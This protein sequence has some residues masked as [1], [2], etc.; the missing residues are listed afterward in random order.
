MPPVGDFDLLPLPDSSCGDRGYPF[1]RYVTGSPTQAEEDV[2]EETLQLLAGLDQVDLNRVVIAGDYV[3]FDERARHALK[4]LRAKVISAFSAHGRRPTNVLVWGAPGSGKSFL[5]QEVARSLGDSARL[6]EANLAQV[7]E[8]GLRDR[9]NEAQSG[10]TDTICFIDELDAHP[11]Q[12]WPYELLLP[13]LEPAGTPVHRTVFIL[14]G[15]AGVDLKEFKDVVRSRPKGPDLLSRIPRGNEYTVPP[16]R[17]GDRI[18]VVTTQIR[19]AAAAEGRPVR[20]FEKFALFYV[21]STPELQTARQLRALA[22]ESARRIPPGDDRFRY[23]HLFAAGD[24]ENKRFWNQHEDARRRLADGFLPVLPPTVVQARAPARTAPPTP[25]PPRLGPANPR[26]RIAILPFLNISSNPADTYFSDG[27]T[28]ELI[29]TVSRIGELRVIARTSVTRFR[30]GSK[31]AAEAAR[32]LQVGTLLEGSVRRAGDDLRVTAQLI[33]VANEEPIW[34]MTFDRRLENVFAIQEELAQRIAHSLSA[35]LLAGER[36]TIGRIPT[37]SVEAYDLY[38]QGRQRFFAVTRDGYQSAIQLFERALSI[39]PAFALAFCGLAEAQALEGNE[40]FV[41]LAGALER[42]ETSART[43]LRLDPDLGEAHV[44]L[45]PILYNRYDWTGALRTLDKAIVVEPNNV[46]AHFWRAV[47][48][49]TLGNPEDGL[50][51]ALRAVELDPL[52]PRRRFILG[53]QYYW[54][55]RFDDAIAVLNTPLL[56]ESLGAKEL[57][58]YAHI[59]AGRPAEALAAVSQLSP[60]HPGFRAQHRVDLAVIYAKTGRTAEARVILE[61]LQNPAAEEH[62]DAGAIAL[63]LS[64]LGEFDSAIEWYTRAHAERSIAGVPDLGVDPILDPLRAVPGF[65]RLLSL[66]NFPVPPSRAG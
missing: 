58:A 21:A 48:V 32:E 55:R 61:G 14:V 63:V 64:A 62:V 38:L 47:V 17:G 44:A 19:N 16:L 18:V 42:A 50:A 10:T 45:A 30:D 35:R 40:G 66:F 41:P 13:A 53:Q 15:S 51:N 34:S 25:D 5:V 29:S 2:E 3:R 56:A 27:L 7:N 49:G 60:G 54:M 31:S 52:N 23:D 59:G 37:R 20:E 11:D 39:D 12:S 28:E 24:P 9:L 22:A 4:D 57:V 26:H 6:V 43:A 65:G 46:Q 36:A 1:G 8:S 33:D